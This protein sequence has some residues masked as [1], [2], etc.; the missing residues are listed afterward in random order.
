M[1]LLWQRQWYSS[2]FES[3]VDSKSFFH[4]LLS[5]S[6]DLPRH[7]LESDRPIVYLMSI[8]KESNTKRDIFLEGKERDLRSLT[9]ITLSMAF[10]A[11]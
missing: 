8:G 2:C 3:D 11:D 4:F 6:F 10:W 9:P 5:T 7:R 1:I